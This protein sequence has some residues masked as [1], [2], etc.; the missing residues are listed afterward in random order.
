[1]ADSSASRHISTT[2]YGSA[3]RKGKGI[4][5]VAFGVTAG[6]LISAS[7]REIP[8]AEARYATGLGCAVASLMMALSYRRDMTERGQSIAMEAIVKEVAARLPRLR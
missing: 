4:A 6:L 5:G 3:V 1:M 7:I 8:R 2:P